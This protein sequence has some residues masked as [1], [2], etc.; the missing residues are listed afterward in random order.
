MPA[1]PAT[2]LTPVPQ[3][4]MARRTVTPVGITNVPEALKV[5]VEITA[6]STREK[7]RKLWNGDQHRPLSELRTAS[8]DILKL[9][10]I[11]QA[12][13]S[14][15]KAAS[16]GCTPSAPAADLAAPTHDFPDL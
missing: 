16:R 3:A 4:W 13:D 15:R 11:R 1:P 9:S 10:F 12:H 6:T 8:L 2:P 14:A 5:W 7:W